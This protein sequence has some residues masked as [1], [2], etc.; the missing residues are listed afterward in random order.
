[1]ACSACQKAAEARKKKQE[2]I[3]ALSRPSVSSTFA[4]PK[5]MVKSNNV[6]GHGRPN[7]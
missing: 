3:R 2:E 1:M 6:H 4:F 7:P 5:P